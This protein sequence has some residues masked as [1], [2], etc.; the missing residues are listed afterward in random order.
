MSWIPKRIFGVDLDD[1]LAYTT[2]KTVRI[3]DRRI[4]LCH[5]ILVL[6]VVA[7]VLGFQILY[8]NEHFKLYDVMGAA[9]VTIQQ[10]TDGGC[11][12]NDNDCED[13]LTPLTE[14]PYC[15]RYAGTRPSSVKYQRRCIYADQ[16]EMAPE[17][18][19]DGSLFIP[20]RIDKLV[21]KRNCT[22]TDSHCRKMWRTEVEKENT[23]VADVEDYTILIVSTYFRKAFRNTSTM[24]QGFYYE[25]R[26]T[27][28]NEVL[29]T[30]PCHGELSVRPI[31]CLPGLPCKFERIGEP[32]RNPSFLEQQPPRRAPRA[33]LLK[34][35]PSS[36]AL[37]SA[38]RG[39]FD[40]FAIPNGDIFRFSKLLQ[41][42]GLKLDGSFNGDGEP[43]RERGT[44]LSVQI[45]YANLRPFR[46][47]LFHDVEPGY[48]YK[49]VE[50][51]MEEMKTE[52]YTKWQ[53]GNENERVMENRHGIYLQVSVTGS[54][55]N[56]NIVYLLLML[57]TSLALLAVAGTVTDLMAQ[58]LPTGIQDQYTKEK[59]HEVFDMDPHEG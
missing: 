41:L 54:F 16:H 15:E 57:T 28:T 11:N 7:W 3:H 6:V 26:D 40:A 17:G 50:R 38:E 59:Y 5:K 45:E 56:F 13:N 51:P 8:S 10:P 22:P 4:G 43:L 53:S 1:A 27:E 48:I 30:D 44:V 33:S 23:Y 19:L 39:K 25:C 20:T 55:G 35:G 34:P 42:A 36:L 9:R 52:L 46:S 58:Y 14:L 29:K 37:H 32:P 47:T 24:H 31:N 49:V 2:V 12:P 21:E 18:M